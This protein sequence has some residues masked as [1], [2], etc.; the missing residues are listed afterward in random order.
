MIILVAGKAGSGKDS[1][2]QYLVDNYGFKHDSLAAPLK[3]L[4]SDVFDI[5]LHI[6]NPHN[7]KDRQ[8]REEEL[9]SWPGWTPRKLLQFVGTELFRTNIA[10]DIWVRSLWLRINKNPTEN[11]TVSDVRFP[12]EREYLVKMA[13]QNVY[14]I[15]V[16]RPGCDGSTSGGIKTHASEAFEI[17][18]DF[19]IKNDSTL[20]DLYAKVDEIL[21]SL[22]ITIN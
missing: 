10:D 1:I 13:P 5:P 11:V 18:A 8:V 3:R 21:K 4:V 16:E 14:T 20:Q 15:R 17:E 6:L 12:N 19:V 22:N 7:P 2:S 9:K